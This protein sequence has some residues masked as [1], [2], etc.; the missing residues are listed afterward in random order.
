VL[1]PPLL[2]HPLGFPVPQLPHPIYYRFTSHAKTGK[3]QKKLLTGERKAGEI[4]NRD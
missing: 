3:I 2:L 4:S 1:Q